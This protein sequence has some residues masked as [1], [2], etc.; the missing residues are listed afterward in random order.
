MLNEEQLDLLDSI[1]QQIHNDSSN[2]N[3]DFWS[4]VSALRGPDKDEFPIKHI[5][6]SI[7]EA[8]TGVIRYK[9]GIMSGLSGLV[10]NK[11]SS[12]SVLVRNLLDNN[13]EVIERVGWHFIQ[14]AKNAFTA[15]GLEWHQLNK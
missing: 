11:D 9:T 14:H 15:L 3:S 12:T 6:V 10:S 4:V 5:P 1:V 7:K 13:N 2:L 8:T